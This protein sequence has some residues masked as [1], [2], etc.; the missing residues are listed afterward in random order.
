[1]AVAELGIDAAVHGVVH[2]EIAK[3]GD[4]VLG[5]G[6][7]DEDALARLVAMPQTHDERERAANS[8]S[9]VAG[10]ATG[11]AGRVFIRVGAEQWM[12]SEGLHMVAP[13]AVILV[14]PFDA[15]GG[16]PHHD[17]TWVDGGEALP[18]DAKSLHG[19]GDIVLQEAIRLRDESLQCFLPFRAREIHGDGELIAR[20][21]VEDSLAIPGTLTRIIIDI[22]HAGVAETHEFQRRAGHLA[23]RA[24]GEVLDGLDADDLRAPVGQ[25]HGAVRSGPHDGDV[26]DAQALKGQLAR[27]GDGRTSH[28]SA[29]CRR[30]CDAPLAFGVIIW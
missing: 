27:T 2:D 15:K 20:V 24:G 25:V 10:D 3:E 18:R 8:A 11:A 7:F 29:V 28:V 12:T 4:E 14:R 22:T 5:G 30:H 26:K 16:H 13:R 17:E 1:M 21:R 23:A 6:G 9:R 19:D